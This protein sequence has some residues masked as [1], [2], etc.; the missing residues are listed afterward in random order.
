MLAEGSSGP[1]RKRPLRRL[2]FPAISLCLAVLLA[3]PV[4]A[5][6]TTN[7]PT[8]QEVPDALTQIGRASC[9]ERVSFTV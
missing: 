7:L 2:I 6:E 8:S 5:R 3:M 4:G 1:A 9:R